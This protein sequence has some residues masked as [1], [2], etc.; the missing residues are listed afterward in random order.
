[1]LEEVEAYEHWAERS[2]MAIDGIFF[3]QTPVSG[4]IATQLYLRN[5]S[6]TVKH[7]SGFL[8]P[9]LVIHNPGRL[10]N[11]NLTISHTDITIIFDGAYSDVPPHDV[12]ES[13]LKEAPGTR[14]N[15]GVMVHSLP[16]EVG[17]VVCRKLINDLKKRCAVH[18]RH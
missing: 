12:L 14:D 4:S 10:P 5:I 18:F 6:A 9:R 16:S 11:G 3:D 2:K 1:V 17:R 7:S 8:A 15:Y 13:E